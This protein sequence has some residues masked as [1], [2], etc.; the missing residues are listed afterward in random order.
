MNYFLRPGFIFFAVK[1]T[2]ILTVLG[3]SVAISLYNR[4]NKLGGMNHFIYHYLPPSESPT[5]LY[6]YPATM[7]LIRM[8]ANRGCPVSDLEAQ[9]YGGAAPQGSS[10]EQIQIGQDNIREA[11]NLLNGYNIPITSRDVGGTMGRKVVFN[12]FTG[13]VIVARVNKIRETDWFYKGEL[14]D[15]G[16]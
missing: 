8:F 12:T 6:A 15:S 9:L 5:S 7:Q 11:E 2:M 16:K 13:E 10:K 1:P 3:S 14:I 4:R